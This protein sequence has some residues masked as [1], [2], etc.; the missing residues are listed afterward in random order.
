MKKRYSFNDHP[1]HKKEL[2]PWADK[3]IHNAMS[4]KPMD[5]KEKAICRE[6]VK[7]LYR[8]ANLDPPPDHRIVFVSSPFIMRFAGGF[9]A[10]IWHKRKTGP[11]NANAEDLA[12]ALAVGRDATYDATGDAALAATR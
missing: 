1:E 5:D 10:A 7:G 11:I 4:T 2:S 9:A 3:W 12:A 8:S 6:A